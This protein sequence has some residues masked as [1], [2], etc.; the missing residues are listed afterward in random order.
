MSS[1]IALND[2]IGFLIETPLFDHLNET[3]LAEFVH[4]LEIRHVDNGDIVFSAG[5]SA[6]AWYVIFKGVVEVFHEAPS[7]PVLLTRLGSR[8]CFGEVAVLDG[9]ERSASIR[10]AV[11]TLLLRVPR[12]A[13]NDALRSG[14]LGAYKLVHRM[15]LIL[16]AR[17]RSANL[18]FASMEGAATAV[19]L[20]TL[21]V[22]TTDRA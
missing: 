9:A 15:A 2:L 19:Q 11:D 6:D 10:A 22:L 5:D 8:A 17:L 21:D 3:E 16:S 1:P 12:A 7:G 13:F 18:Q 14:S 4:L 20:P